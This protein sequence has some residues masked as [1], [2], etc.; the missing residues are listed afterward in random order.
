MVYDMTLIH[1]IA[2]DIPCFT[3]IVHEMTIIVFNLLP[4]IQCILN[5][6]FKKVG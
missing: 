2:C 5:N 3:Y 1:D 6:I 4:V